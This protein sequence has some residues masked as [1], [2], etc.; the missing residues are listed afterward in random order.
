MDKGNINLNNNDYKNLIE[1]SNS[2]ENLTSF[3]VEEKYDK[4]FEIVKYNELKSS[5]IIIIFLIIYTTIYFF[6]SMCL[7][8]ANT[9]GPEV[10]EK[11]EIAF[12][13][14]DFIGSFIF[15]LVEGISL[16]MSNIV[17]VG[18]LRFYLLVLNIG[19]TLTGSILFILSPEYWEIT[20]HWIEFSA[21]VFLTLTDLIFISVQFK[22]NKDNILYKYRY[23]ELI[24]V[25]MLLFCS[26]FKL[27]IF[28][29]V[30]YFGIDPEQLAHY[31]EFSGEM[32]NSIFALLF[33]TAYYDDI[34]LKIEN[35]SRKFV[36]RTN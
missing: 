35:L 28:G 33:L 17:V 29:N 12:H 13:S 26:I 2:N 18:E 21:Q 7:F 22:R 24:F 4:E 9:Q 25:I 14:L 3:E 5:S 36:S 31:F 23:Y 19:M 16:I 34:T 27:F 30:F 1:E 20:S 15:A 8:I 6:S 11:F 32:A 10:I